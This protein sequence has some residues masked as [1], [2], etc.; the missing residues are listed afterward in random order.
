MPLEIAEALDKLKG[1]EEATESE[2]A[3][4]LQEIHIEQLEKEI[5]W[6]DG[7]LR[8]ERP[9]RSLLARLLRR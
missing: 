3:A 9:L 2:I 1:D 4:R 6:L 7:Q 5:R 8:R